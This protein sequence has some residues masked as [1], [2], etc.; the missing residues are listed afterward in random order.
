MV[1]NMSLRKWLCSVGRMP[2]GITAN[3]AAEKL[4]EKLSALET[5]NKR[6]RE[7]I[8]VFLGLKEK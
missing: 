3:E 5:E 2:P 7:D 8:G 1:R 6:L 4:I